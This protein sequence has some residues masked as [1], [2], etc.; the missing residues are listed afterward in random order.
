MMDRAEMAALPADEVDYSKKW[1][2]MS[3]IAMGIFLATIDG[4]IVNV[5]LPTLTVELN[6]DFSSVQW[7]VLSYLLTVTILQAIVG[8]LA[9][10][11]GRKHLYNGGFVVFTIGSALCGLAPTAEWLILARV[12]QGIGGA[13]T[14]AL[15]MAI[16][17]DAFP[18][19]ER[20]RA[21]SG[22]GRFRYLALA[23]V[24]R[25]EH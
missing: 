22:D 15:G 25:V 4:S 14:L 2:V 1:H 16:I 17:T 11:H 18:A 24:D 20:G 13:M 6:T 8:R 9:D 21:L 12:L 7:V 5:A 19:G 10:M 23:G 3:A